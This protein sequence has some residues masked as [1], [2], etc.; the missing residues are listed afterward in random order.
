MEKNFLVYKH[1]KKGTDEVF[2]IGKGNI[3]RSKSKKRNRFWKSI[4][5][6]YDYDIKI[7]EDDLTE[8]EAFELEIKLIKEY[9]RRGW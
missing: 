4:V 5:A 6:K 7:V 9:G 3:K 1:L 2:Y 8:Q